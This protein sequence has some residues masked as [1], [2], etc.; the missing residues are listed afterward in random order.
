MSTPARAHA[1]WWTRRRVAVV[2][3]V[4]ALVAYAGGAWLSASQS[5]MARR[6]LLDGGPISNLPYRWVT[7]PPALADQNKP[8][9]PGDFT[10]T[11]AGEDSDAGV[12]STN[13]QQ[14]S[15]VLSRGAIKRIPGARSVHMTIEPLDPATLGALPSGLT[16][17][18]NAYRVTGTYRPGGEAVGAFVKSAL[19]VFKYPGLLQHG[20]QRFVVFGPDGTTWTKLETT[21]DATGLQASATPDRLNGFYE[22]AA[23]GPV[24][25]GTPAGGGSGSALPWIVIG[26]AV[27]VAAVLVAL[28]WR[29]RTR[30][31]AA[32]AP[33]RPESVEPGG[34]A[35][36][37][38]TG[39]V[40]PR[41]SSTRRSPKK[42][43]RR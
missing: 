34:S 1:G 10:I 28:R 2:A 8:P 22:V 13:D 41:G 43:R 39:S 4:A 11:F 21:D 20:N 23:T 27:V 6:P 37:T 33:P 36:P 30:A 15:V 5:P 16:V 14:A 29:A 9:T 25:A 40:A 32:T 7:P 12:F 17:L 38:G 24:S 35:P 19:V 26:V 3:G 42:K 31:R 18:G